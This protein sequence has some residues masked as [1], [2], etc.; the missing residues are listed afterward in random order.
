MRVVPSS[1]VGQGHPVEAGGPA[2]CEMALDPDAVPTG[3]GG[4]V[5]GGLLIGA[6]RVVRSVHARSRCGEWASPHLVSALVNSSGRPRELG[7]G[8]GT[9]SAG[10][11]AQQ[12]QAGRF[13]N[14]FAPVGDAEL[15]VDVAG[16]GAH[17][18]DRDAELAGDVRPTQITLEQPQDVELALAERV[19]QRLREAAGADVSRR[20]SAATLAPRRRRALPSREGRR[21]SPAQHCGAAAVRRGP[22]SRK[23][24]MWPSRRARTSARCTR[25]VARARCRL[26]PRRPAPAAPGSRARCPSGRPPPRRPAAARAAGRLVRG[27]RRASGSV[28]GQQHHRQGDVLELVQVGEARHRRQ[29]RWCWTRTTRRSRS[30]RSELE[31]GAHRGD[32]AHVRGEVSEVHLLGLVEQIHGLRQASSCAACRR[33]WATRQR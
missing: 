31:S 2:R 15:G 29:G 18:V 25:S 23:T 33:A 27:R 11:V 20:G 8:S 6:P 14:G 3:V 19:D 32:G 22:A 12:A 5:A 7:S 4:S 30:P 10:V 24:R 1:C 26:G 9:G 28:L 16:V 21:A 13:A 17:R